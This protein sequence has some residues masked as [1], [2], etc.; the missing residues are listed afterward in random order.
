MDKFTNSLYDS[1][2]NNNIEESTL[3]LAQYGGA[4]YFMNYA[5]DTL[6]DAKNSISESASDVV[7]STK[8][9]LNNTEG[10][11]NKVKNK[12]L[13]VADQFINGKP[14]L[15][16]I[17]P[18]MTENMNNNTV[19]YPQN[20][21][22]IN[23]FNSNDNHIATEALVDDINN[24]IKGG[25]DD[26]LIDNINKITGGCNCNK[27]YCGGD[28]DEEDDYELEGGCNCNKQYCGGDDDEENDEEYDSDLDYLDDEEMDY[29][30]DDEDII[31]D[32]GA[33]NGFSG[34]LNNLYGDCMK[35]GRKRH[36]HTEAIEWNKKSNDFII[37]ELK[38]TDWD[39]IKA[40]KFIINSKNKEK[41]GEN[42]LKNMND[43][44]RAKLLYDTLT[45]LTIKD[46]K[47]IDLN[48]VKKERTKLIKEKYGDRYREPTN[49]KTEVESKTET[50]SSVKSSKSKDVKK[51]SSKKQKGGDD[52]DSLFLGGNDDEDEDEET[53]QL[54]G[55]FKYDM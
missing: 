11:L 13:D 53:I 36:F 1:E 31:M 26:E 39:D 10:F 38:I 9:L 51:K 47:K 24:I 49:K 54:P 4:S 6:N 52:L 30:N 23:N 19:K 25:N 43:I 42:E 48:K 44:E 46:I 40:I 41:Y 55:N 20:S 14:N 27:Q 18:L 22:R 32:G 29:E 12:A 5:S 50:K 2:V 3:G 21:Q 16:S 33:N 45:K 8:G 7:N 28:D 15:Q 35:G 17:Q 34:F 37:N